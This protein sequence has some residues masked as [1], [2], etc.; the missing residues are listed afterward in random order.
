MKPVIGRGK[1]PSPFG[2]GQ[3]RVSMFAATQ[4]LT[5]RAFLEREPGSRDVS[6]VLVEDFKSRGL[7]GW[8]A[9][10]RLIGPNMQARHPRNPRNPRLI[11]NLNS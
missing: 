4:T 9:H 2:R 1:S 7:R 5:R 11:R 8:R 6:W 3:V 10:R